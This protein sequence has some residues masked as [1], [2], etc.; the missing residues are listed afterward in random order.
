MLGSV[1][2]IHIKLYDDS[3]AVYIIKKTMV[4]K[5]GGGGI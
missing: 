3:M 4:V 2:D 1:E 5:D